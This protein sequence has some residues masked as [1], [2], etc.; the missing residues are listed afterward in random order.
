MRMGLVPAPLA[1]LVRD[2]GRYSLTIVPLSRLPAVD[3]HG[4]PDDGGG[5]VRAQPDGGGDLL[6]PSHPPDR[7]LCDDALTPFRRAGP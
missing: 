2:M 7:L 5:R 6:G 4:V 1:V 3:D